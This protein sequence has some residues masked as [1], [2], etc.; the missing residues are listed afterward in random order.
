[1]APSQYIDSLV[2]MK[3]RKKTTLCFALWAVFVG[4]LQLFHFSK[5]FEV[6][7][8][9]ASYFRTNDRLRLRLQIDGEASW[10]GTPYSQSA[11]SL[12]DRREIICSIPSLLAPLALP[13]ACQAEEQRVANPNI[14]EIEDPET[15]SA[16][17]YIPTKI[18]QDLK[19]LPL[20]VVLHGAGNNRKSAL[21]EFTNLG[22]STSPPGD[23]TQLPLALMSNNQAPASLT[24]N[25]VVV[26]PYV[27]K[28]NRGS[29]YDEPRTK[30]IAF[31]KWFRK[32]VEEEH[33][34]TINAQHVSLFGFSEGATLA[35]ELATTRLFNALVLASYGFTG[36]LPKLALERLNGIPVWVFH[37]I[38]D[39]VYDIQCSKRLVD[40][41]I[42]Y[43]GGTDVFDVGDKIKFTKLKPLEKVAGDTSNKGREHVRS[44]LIA[45]RSDEVFEWL[46]HQ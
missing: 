1:M 11:N 13:S 45:S 36:S 33:S 4:C 35:V 41:L 25:F 9:S 20:I 43:Q 19:A 32:W 44:A 8:G 26:A 10:K 22:S 27:G 46:L 34:V 28:G 42:T 7:V 24:N 14:F 23:H 39:D 5:A 12:L 37:S 17:T 15:Y 18:D 29:L 16:V 40:S 6:Q 31:I 21:Y 2:I 30:I 38:G 3:T